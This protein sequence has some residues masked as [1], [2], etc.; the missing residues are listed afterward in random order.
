MENGLGIVKVF[1]IWCNCG[2]FDC[3]KELEATLSYLR[4]N[5]PNSDV[6]GYSVDIRE[7][8]VVNSCVSDVIRKYG[9]IDALVN[10]AGIGRLEAFEK[11]G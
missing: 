8:E 7:Q 6:C 1:L 3:A 2:Y 11:N 9:H 5:F 10:N 4:L